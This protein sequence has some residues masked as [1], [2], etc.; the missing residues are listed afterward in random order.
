[1][2]LEFG[3][4]VIDKKGKVLGKVDHLVRDTWTG[5][6]RKFMVRRK[7]PDDDLFLS[8]DDVAEAT[9]NTVKLKASVEELNQRET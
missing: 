2:E 6:T 3:A 4:E 7:A 5:E 1:M 9:E 8:V